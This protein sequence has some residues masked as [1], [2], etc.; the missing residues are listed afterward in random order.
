MYYSSGNIFL[1][2]KKNQH[3]NT[4]RYDNVDYLLSPLDNKNPRSKGGNSN[5][6]KIVNPQTDEDFVI[7]FSKYDVNSPL[8]PANNIKR[9]ARFSREIEALTLSKNKGFKNIIQYFFDDYKEIGAGNFHYYVM[10]KADFDLTKYLDQNEISEQQRF[11]LC[12]QILNGIQELHGEKI[13]HRDIKPDNILFVNKQWKIG[14]LGLV[15]Y[16]DSDIEINEIGEKIGPIGWLSP[17]AANKF[18][19]EGDGK[20]NRYG[21]DCTID[22]ASDI[23]Q[24]GKLFWYIFQGNIPIGQ[25]GRNDFRL[26]DKVIFDMIYNMLNHSKTRPTLEEVEQGF[27]SRYM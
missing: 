3:K 5:V 6:F 8:K 19:N 26:K 21:F 2:P 11:F 25:V 17:E 10:E 4:I 27:K 22:T 12:I 15:D 7:K 20:T 1:S 24:L 18:L 23:F 16:R 9:I 14:D 13:Y